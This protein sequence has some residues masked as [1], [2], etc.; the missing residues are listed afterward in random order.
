MPPSDYRASMEAHTKK[1]PHAT[2]EE[3]RYLA[4]GVWHDMKRNPKPLTYLST[5]SCFLSPLKFYLR[6]SAIKKTHPAP[7]APL[8]S[9]TIGGPIDRITSLSRELRDN[10]NAN[11]LPETI[12]VRDGVINP[13]VSNLFVNRQFY[14]E[15]RELIQKDRVYKIECSSIP[16]LI[17]ALDNMPT[18][19]LAP[20]KRV[21]ITTTG[22]YNGHAASRH[23]RGE[24]CGN[25]CPT[26]HLENGHCRFT[27]ALACSS[28]RDNRFYRQEL[29]YAVFTLVRKIKRIG[30]PVV[31]ANILQGIP[32]GPA[33]SV[34]MDMTFGGVNSSNFHRA[35]KRSVC[36]Y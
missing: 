2:P 20:F 22:P 17:R 32:G 15:C 26:I 34:R 25:I 23:E 13:M 33:N 30:G 21:I 10:I 5:G 6:R 36:D 9:T 11:V 16:K 19:G 4:R 7:A 12:L 28:C 27:I 35:Y 24:H 14:K 31:P 18:G 3:D 29:Q 1:T 8:A